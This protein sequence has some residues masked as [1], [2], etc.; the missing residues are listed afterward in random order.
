MLMTAPVT[1]LTEK[2]VHRF[3]AINEK[4]SV[5]DVTDEPRVRK[6]PVKKA[7]SQ[8]RPAVGVEAALV[9]KKKR[10]TKGKPMVIAQEAVPLH[11]IEAI[12]NAPVE[13]PPVPKIKSQKRR[14]RLVL[15]AGDGTVDEQPA[16]EVESTVEKQPA[17]TVSPATVEVSLPSASVDISRITLG[18]EIHI[19]DVTERTWYLAGLPQ[20]PVDDKGK[21]PLLQK[22]PVKGNPVQEQILLIG[23]DVEC[24]VQ[25][26]EKVIGEVEEFFHSF[27]RLKWAKLQQE[28]FSAKIEQVLTW[29]ETDSTIIALQR[30]AYVLLKYREMLLR[31]F[32]EARILNFVPGEV[33]SATDLKILDRLSDIHLFV[34]EELKDKSQEHS[35]RWDRTCCSKIFEGR[36]HDRGAVIARSNTN[37]KSSCWIRK[38]LIVDGTWVIEP[39]ADYWKPIP[40]AELSSMVI[41]PSR[42]SYVDTLP[43]MCDFFNLLRKR[44]ADVCIEVAQFFASGKL[45]LVGVIARS[46]TNTKSSCWIRK[47]LIVDGTWVI[48]PCADYWKPIPRAE[49]SSMVIIPSRLSYVDTL[50]PMC[51]FFNL[52][53]KRWADV[54]IE[55]AQFFA[56]GKLLLVGSINFCRGLSV[57]E[58]VA[59]FAPRQPTVFSLRVSQFC[60][61]F[62]EYNFFSSLL[63]TVDFSSLR[64]VVIAD[65]GIDISVDSGVQRSSVLLT[66][67]I[68]QDVQIADATVFES[69]NVQIIQISVLVTPFVQLLDE[70]IFSAST[71]ENSAM[72]FDETDIATTVSSLPTVSTDLSTSLANLQTILSEHIDASQGGI[73]SK[74]HKIEQGFRDSLRQQEEAFKTLIQGARQESRNIDNVQTLRFN[75]FRKNVLAQNA[76]VF[77]GLT[78]VRKEVQDINAK[79]DIVATGLNE[80]LKD[81]EATKEA[82]SH[83]LLDFQSQAQANYIILTEQLGQLV[84]YINR[85]GNAKKGKERAAEDLNH[86][87]P[88]KSETVAMQVVVVMLVSVVGLQLM[89]YPDASYSN[90][91]ERYSESVFDIKSVASYS[92]VE[93]SD[94]GYSDL[95]I[96]T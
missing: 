35:L 51:D 38:M 2:T 59:S 49:L 65:R 92:N 1:I 8:K 73:L 78:D 26:R 62:I 77:T 29:A 22:D 85:G 12:A 23:A 84:D 74:L 10:T 63:S 82:I 20:I 68:E 95:H 11:I 25:L 15:S 48:E 52:L 56:S 18:K 70:H 60:T 50:P 41:I 34:L 47:M 53:R 19:P 83:L 43:P 21:E 28:D 30:K 86:H 88:F 79:V 90:P 40:R 81:V 87:L 61:V 69:Q 6:T 17:V 93:L 4:F 67:L 96:Q 91:D 55:V 46:N 13:Q 33:E 16:A 42:L 37:T 3:V 57:V 64:S 31:K 76:S 27:S 75:E 71:S 58:P 66:E 32:I 94:V 24:L 80:V 7:V 44:W 45:L 9:V 72:H 14:R 5:E 89:G 39:C 54:C 36:I